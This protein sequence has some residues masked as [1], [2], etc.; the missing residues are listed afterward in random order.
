MFHEWNKNKWLLKEKI[1][2]EDKRKRENGARKRKWE[3]N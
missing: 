3:E 1:E 2:N